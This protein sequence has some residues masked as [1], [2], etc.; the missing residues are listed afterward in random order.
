MICKT[1]CRK[2]SQDKPP[3]QID[4]G[5]LSSLLRWELRCDRHLSVHRALRLECERVFAHVHADHVA[6]LVGVGENFAG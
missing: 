3:N 1:Q 4:L 6:G 2:L 5:G